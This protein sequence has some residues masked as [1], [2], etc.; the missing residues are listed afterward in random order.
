M[1]FY[2]KMYTICTLFYNTLSPFG[3]LCMSLHYVPLLFASSQP[4]LYKIYGSSVFLSKSPLVFCE[5]IFRVTPKVRNR[6]FFNPR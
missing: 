3:E 1:Y 2:Y 6:Y 4:R 5:C